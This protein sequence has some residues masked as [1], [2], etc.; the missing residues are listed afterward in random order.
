MHERGSRIAGATAGGLGHE[1]RLRTPRDSVLLSTV[2][3]AEMIIDIESSRLAA[4]L[5]ISEILARQQVTHAFVGEIAVGAWT[6]RR[7][8]TGAVDLLALVSPDRCQQIPTMASHRGFA[9]DP[10]DVDAARELD[11]IPMRWGGPAGPRVHVLMA[12]N[13]L[14]AKMLL[15]VAEAKLGEATVPV[16]HA[17]DLALMLVLSDRDDVSVDE[18]AI[19]AGDAFD[20]ARFDETLRTIGL[21]GKAGAR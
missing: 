5:A 17:E 14:Y 13:A 16:V 7:V 12:T 10:A 1:S 20:R 11:L 8:E 9:V 3:M 6:G 2:A 18:L 19:R 21:A 4:A 15:R